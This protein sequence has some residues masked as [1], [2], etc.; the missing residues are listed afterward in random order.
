MLGI[1]DS[2]LVIGLVLGRGAERAV[3]A[4]PYP[5]AFEPHPGG[6]LPAA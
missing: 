2:R 1:G 4:R 5:L 3:A 6:D